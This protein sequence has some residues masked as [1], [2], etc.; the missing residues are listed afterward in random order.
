MA[1]KGTYAV[2]KH[3]PSGKFFVVYKTKLS[4]TIGVG[5]VRY[6]DNAVKALESRGFKKV[7]FKISLI[8]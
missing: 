2:K 5:G 7:P 1:I 6:K 3:L 8:G 4:T